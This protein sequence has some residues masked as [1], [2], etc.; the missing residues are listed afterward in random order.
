VINVN[1]DSVLFSSS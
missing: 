1:Q